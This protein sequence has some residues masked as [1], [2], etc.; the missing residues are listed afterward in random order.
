LTFVN[1]WL[2]SVFFNFW[3]YESL[4]TAVTFLFLLVGVALFT[5]S[6]RKLLS[7][8]QR[9]LGPNSTG[10]LGLFQAIADGVKLGLKEAASPTRASI[11]MF[12]YSPLL[13]FALSLAS[14]CAVP[15]AGEVVGADPTM[16]ALS[17]LAITSLSVYGVIGAG[18]S[19]NSRYA[20]IG[21]TRSVAQFISYEVTL[22]FVVVSVVLLSNSLSLNGIVAAQGG[23]ESVLG[24]WFISPLFPLAFL[25]LISVLAETNRT[26][27]DLPEAE[28]EIVA[29]YNVEYSGVL[30]AF[31]FLGEYGNML[32]MAAFFVI[33]FFAGW[34][35]PF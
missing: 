17:V 7:G 1:A 20:L 12:S 9:R 24:V 19:S 13:T 27:F 26:P 33:F 5:L 8:V 4:A 32:L 6:E 16:S 35:A 3:C 22:G 25:F 15:L 30:F 11:F 28:A 31:F 18:W 21:A 2:L 10:V 34:T 14:W 29:G 23:L